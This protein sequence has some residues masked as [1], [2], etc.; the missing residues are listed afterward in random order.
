[1]ISILFVYI[2]TISDLVFDQLFINF[3]RE[4]K[5]VDY[6]VVETFVF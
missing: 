4:K 1:M 2:S 6:T 3:T 5:L